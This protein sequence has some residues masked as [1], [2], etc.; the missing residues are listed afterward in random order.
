MA[1]G[2]RQEDCDCYRHFLPF[3]AG[4]LS[5]KNFIACK[6]TS[7]IPL[8]RNYIATA[9]VYVSISYY[10]SLNFSHL[11]WHLNWESSH[12]EKMHLRW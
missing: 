3:P 11:L 5:P 7:A 8:F 9:L 4:D 12:P 6:N 10:M 2:H 1:T